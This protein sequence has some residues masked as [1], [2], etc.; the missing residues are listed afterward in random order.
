MEKQ[1]FNKID[2]ANYL[3]CSGKEL[4]KI[5]VKNFIKPYKLF[6]NLI[7]YRR[8]DLRYFLKHQRERDDKIIHEE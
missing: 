1:W 6:G 2:A 4:E 8:R 7:R 5:S 3:G